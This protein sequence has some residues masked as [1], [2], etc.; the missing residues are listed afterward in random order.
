M[1]YL[2]SSTV[3]YAQFVTMFSCLFIP[4]RACVI[5]W[6][7]CSV[8][9]I[10]LISNS[11]FGSLRFCPV[12]CYPGPLTIQGGRFCLSF[13]SSLW[14]NLLSSFKHF[15]S[16]FKPLTSLISY[17]IQTLFKSFPFYLQIPIR[18]IQ[19]HTIQTNIIN[20]INSLLKLNSR[21]WQVTA[22][23]FCHHCRFDS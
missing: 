10:V 9:G 13:S 12:N 21:T 6:L 23:I 16:Y 11:C 14:L 5:G 17:V 3:H 15:I 2:T 1:T 22:R 18:K 4:T 7:T 8:D 19:N 20:L